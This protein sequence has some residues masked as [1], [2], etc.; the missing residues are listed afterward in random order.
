MG[1]LRRWPLGA[2]LLLLLAG[3][4]VTGAGA[5]PSINGEHWGR[6]GTPF[7]LNVG[8][9]VRGDWGRYLDRAAG[10]WSESNVAE[11]RVVAGGARP[12]DCRGTDGRV[13]ICSADYGCDGNKCWLGLTNLV[14]RG[15]HL[16]EASIRLN[17][18]FFNEPG[19]RYNNRE[20]RR[21][22]ICHELGHALGLGHSDNGSC[23]NDSDE[24]IF[25]NLD[26][27]KS[28]FKKLRKL[29][30]HRDDKRDITLGG[31][32]RR[33]AADDRVVAAAP[34]VFDPATIA[35]VEAAPGGAHTRTIKK[36][37][38]GRTMVTYITW[39]EE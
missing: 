7:T 20:A 35:N 33:S 26:P 14:F 18:T 31:S 4:L 30:N 39:V 3:P 11:L 9:N 8:D 12:E 28:D 23:M 5:T 27:V 1:N 21:H 6:R 22:T 37:P 24:A 2:V 29:Y 16:T 10:E 36:L 32:S 34:D 25:A 19:G 17:D 38:D 15:D 13:E